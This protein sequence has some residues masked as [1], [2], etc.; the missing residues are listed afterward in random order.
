MKTKLSEP[1]GLAFIVVDVLVCVLAVYVWAVRRQMHS[2]CARPVAQCVMAMLVVLTLGQDSCAANYVSALA[3]AV[4]LTLIEHSQT[5]AVF[6]IATLLGMYRSMHAEH[7]DFWHRGTAMA[8]HMYMLLAHLDTR[9][10]NTLRLLSRKLMYKQE[11][12]LI[13]LNQLREIVFDDIWELPE[14]FRLHVICGEFTYNV[15]EPLFLIRAIARMVWRPLLPLCILQMLV[16]SLSVLEVVLESRV[17]HCLDSVSDY[18]WHHGYVAAL[19][20]LCLKAADTQ[21]SRLKD[22]INSE[23][24]RAFSAVELEL[25][26][27]PLSVNLRPVRTIYSFEGYVQQLMY[28]LKSVQTLLNRMF[29]ILAAFWPVYYRVG[30]LAFVPIAVVVGI[31]LIDRSFGA[32]FGRKNEWE[33]RSK[34]HYRYD[35]RVDEIFDGA[36]SIKLFGW[37]QMYLD[38]KLQIKDV[39]EDQKP[40]F[41]FIVRFA[42]SAIE[43]MSNLASNI[44]SYVVIHYHTLNA[45]AHTAKSFTN[46]NMHELNSHT[47]TLRFNVQWVFYIMRRMNSIVRNNIIIE[48]RLKCQLA[49]TLPQSRVMSV[50]VVPS[51]NLNEC[52]FKWNT[53]DTKPVLAN[54]TLSASNGE[55]VALVGKTGSGKTSLLLSICG[56][57]EMD[58]GGGK[59]VGRI[60]YL[61]QSPWIMNDTLRANVL[62]GRE[63]D[64]KLF[65]KVVHACALAEDIAQWPDADLTVIGDRGINISGGQRARLALARTLYS[66]ADVYILD[67]PLS[68]VDAH[69]K[70]HIMEHVILDTGMLGGKL[71]IVSTHLEHILPFASQIVRLDDDVVSVTAQTPQQYQPVDAATHLSDDEVSVSS[72]GTAVGDTG[73]PS[74]PASPLKPKKTKDDDEDKPVERKWS[75]WE[76]AVY[77]YK[78]CGLTLVAGIVL[79]GFI[80]P[81][82]GFILD[83]LEL[84]ALKDNSS[85]SFDRGALLWYLQLRMASSLSESFIEYM[86]ITTNMLI[87]ERYLESSVKHMFIHSLLFAPM[88]FFDSTTRQEVSSVYNNGARV[89]SSRIPNFLMH[90]LAYVLRIFLSVYHVACSTPYLLV[91][92]PLIGWVTNKRDRLIDPTQTR[93]RKI[94]RSMEI[95]RDRTSHVIADGKRMIR[96]FGVESYFTNR[97]IENHDESQRL[98]APLDALHTLMYSASAVIYSMGD[99]VISMMLLLQSQ[100]SSFKTTSSEYI[101]CQRLLH[102]L[103]SDTTRVVNF[104]SRVRTFSDSIDLYRQFTLIEPEAPYAVDNNSPPENWPEHGKVEFRNFSMRYHDDLGTALDN[105]NLV[106]NPGEK[107]GIVGRTGAGKSSL[108]KV[109][110][111]LVNTGISGSIHIDGQDISTI[112]LGDLRPRLG[113]I[114]QE[115]TIFSGSYKQNLDPLREFTM[116]DIWASLLKCNIAERV[117]PKVNRNS[118]DRDVIDNA[119]YKE[120]LA[121]ANERWSNASW[122]VRLLLLLFMKW[123]KPTVR[124]WN[125][126]QYGINRYCSSSSFSN[127]QQQLFSLC[128]L[129]LRKRRIIILD[130]AT[131]NVDLDTDKNIQ[132]LIRD[133]FNECTV[134]TIAHRLET[135]MNSDRIVVM[136]KGKVVEVGPPKELIAKGGMFAELVQTSS[137]GS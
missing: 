115:S 2:L 8:L 84:T 63:Y 11:W 19:A 44:S 52:S 127:G 6:Q 96:L 41:A 83:S 68:A 73:M 116:E 91:F 60:G 82:S 16:Q 106:I 94:N 112:G 40:W 79:S 104:P 39:D 38:P 72:S 133:E 4:N 1:P 124:R 64:R 29:G 78:L 55:L 100:I 108:T 86:E 128:R 48:K 90:E 28:D 80:R 95:S 134:L 53:T 58:T 34:H 36:K 85:T 69:V 114:P 129:L 99:M 109:L 35:G 107:V 31:T 7:A 81:I 137:F 22:Y 5:F 50:G 77:V 125:I 110:F 131:A 75:N 98:G 30:K 20:L 47:E 103:V 117:S 18:A 27:L 92:V 24:D 89:V 119:F 33:T 93:L 21:R 26:R 3:V 101:T 136:D 66:Q 71:R 61:E 70:R 62:F 59:V 122:S 51:V 54:V 135:V 32:L 49:N 123:P 67:D 12:Q 23:I 102:T 88:S 105:I 130:E 118:T 126:R 87:A 10:Q 15:N 13:K 46:A 76:N 14:R 56:E 121:E 45:S 43:L 120:E 25:F 65:K 111:R 113:I 37:E 17:L 42:W 132:R 74:P 57:V 9:S 97:Y